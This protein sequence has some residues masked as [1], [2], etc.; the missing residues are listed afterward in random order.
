MKVTVGISV[1]ERREILSTI[2][3]T[4]PIAVPIDAKTNGPSLKSSS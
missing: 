3:P 1:H 2:A 4:S